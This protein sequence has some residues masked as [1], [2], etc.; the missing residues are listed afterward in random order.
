MPFASR[1][2]DS[3]LHGVTDYSVGALLMSVLPKLAG[4]E[5]TRTARQIRTSG[6]LHAAY[7][8]LTDYPSVSRSCSRSRPIWRSMRP[9]PWPSRQRPS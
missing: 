3:T 5:G 9:A 2:I 4:V 8:T 1:P 6:A 7:S